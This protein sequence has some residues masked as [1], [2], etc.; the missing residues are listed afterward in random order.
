MDGLAL[1]LFIARFFIII[2]LGFAVKFSNSSPGTEERTSDKKWGR[3]GWGVGGGGGHGSGGRGTANPHTSFGRVDDWQSQEINIK[4]GSGCQRK[5]V[6]GVKAF[7]VQPLKALATVWAGRGE[8]GRAES[9]LIFL[10]TLWVRALPARPSTSC[11]CSLK[12]PADS[13]NACQNGAI[14]RGQFPILQLVVFGLR[15]ENGTRRELSLLR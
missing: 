11:P 1:D 15:E 4:K 13:E 7:I 6:K 5:T 8:E 3:W 14:Q 12:G 9:T 2:S 10:L